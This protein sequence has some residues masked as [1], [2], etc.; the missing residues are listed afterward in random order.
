MH[1]DSVRIV[2]E[3]LLS[4]DSSPSRKSSTPVPA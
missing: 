2:D 4:D 3:Q 1:K